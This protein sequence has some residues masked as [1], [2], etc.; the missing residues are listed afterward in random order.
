[1]ASLRDLVLSIMPARWREDAIAESREWQTTCRSCGALSNTYDLGA[2]RWK[3]RGN[4]VI[5]SRC[6]A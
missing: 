5:R 2:L 3:A 4:K 6:P 1:M